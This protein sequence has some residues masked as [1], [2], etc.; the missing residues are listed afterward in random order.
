V[1]CCASPMRVDN[2]GGLCSRIGQ[3]IG[4]G[5][6]GGGGVGGGEIDGHASKSY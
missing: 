6:A 5:R 2:G 4:E 3:H 1:P